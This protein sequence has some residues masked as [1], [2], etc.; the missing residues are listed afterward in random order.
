MEGRTRG[1]IFAAQVTSNIQI[2][3]SIII[4]NED[5]CHR[6]DLAIVRPLHCR[7]ADVHPETIVISKDGS[8]AVESDESFHFRR[9]VFYVSTSIAWW[10]EVGI[11]SR[12]RSQCVLQASCSIQYEPT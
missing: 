7:E 4:F 10:W 2:N 6:L 11:V 3:V 1:S 12:S 8:R 9:K 5:R